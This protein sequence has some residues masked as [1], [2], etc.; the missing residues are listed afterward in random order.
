M[1]EFLTDLARRVDSLQHGNT[2]ST[3]SVSRP[4]RTQHNGPSVQS[5]NRDFSAVTKC[6]YRLVQLE[7]HDANW[8]KLPKA[9]DDRLKKLI[10][11]INPPMSD[12]DFKRD[13]SKIVKE[14]GDRIA[15]LARQHIGKKLNEK[16]AEAAGLDPSDIHRASEIA[17]K[18]L[19]SRLGRRLDASRRATLLQSAVAM[20]GSTRIQST[21]PQPM[22]SSNNW[23][24]VT[25]TGRADKR[26]ASTSGS[27]PTEN[28]FTALSDDSNDA[29]NDGDDMIGVEPIPTEV[30]RSAKKKSRSRT[31]TTGTTT[32]PQPPRNTGMS[33]SA[34]GSVRTGPTA[35][36]HSPAVGRNPVI[37]HKGP[38]K[39]WLILPDTMVHT[40]V[41]GDSNLRH[42]SNSPR[43]WQVFCLPGA[44]LN[45][46][47]YAL[48]QLKGNK[49][50]TAI[51]QAGI[52]HRSHFDDS[53]ESEFYTLMQQITASECSGNIQQTYH[54]GIPHTPC[55][56]ND[57]RRNTDRINDLFREAFKTGNCIPPPP[58]DEVEISDYD[59]RGIHYTEQT[60]HKIMDSII[61]A[62]SPVF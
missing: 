21:P 38:K 7:H 27:T 31:T 53:L 19:D 20:I 8:T 10:D 5:E 58:D 13:L 4:T 2:V 22:A 49:K 62:V 24:T 45:D 1:T 57:E 26:K 60:A 17:S 39:E 28:R 37:V 16:R 56:S 44:H 23:I 18:Y 55:M 59:I 41:I 54:V 50:Y 6:L 47:T 32:P 15:T 40:I 46:I 11:D 48:Q 34:A 33:T 51:I 14:F 35:V 25:G 9:I 30:M 42:M 3:T 12:E 61:R 43:G 36:I 29:E 52:N